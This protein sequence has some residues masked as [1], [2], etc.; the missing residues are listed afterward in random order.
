MGL[1]Y[2]SRRELLARTGMATLALGARA[3]ASADPQQQRSPGPYRWAAGWLLWR[4]FAPRRIELIEALRDLRDVGA[5]GIELTPRPGELEAAGLTVE[6]VK[7]LLGDHGLQV[8]AHYLSGPFDEPARKDDVMAAAQAKI[9]SLRTFGATHL[10][11]GPP[12]PPADGD[13]R[14]SIA[15]MAPVL[16]EIGKRALDHG[17]VTGIHPHLN[18]VVETV[19]EA[20]LILSLCDAKYVGLALDT[21]HVHLAGGDVTSVLKRHGERLNYLHFKDAVRPF[22]RPDFFPNL[23]ELG[24]GE[25][26]FPAVMRALAAIGYRGWINVEQDATTTTPRDSLQTSMRYV[27]DVLDRPELRGS[28]RHRPR[29]ER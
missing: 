5:D 3:G 7:R 6:Q 18:T 13:R 26:D 16:T 14:R 9:D 4:D 8:S 2:L 1:T 11:I 19:E 20:D 27:R 22:V 28:P 12:A 25:V 10:V 24:R 23:R 29:G 21:G 15:R 17:I